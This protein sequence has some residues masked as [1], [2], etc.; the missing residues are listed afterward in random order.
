MGVGGCGFAVEGL[1]YWVA[2]PGIAGPF[3]DGRRRGGVF[4]LFGGLGGWWWCGGGGAGL[5]F[6]LYSLYGGLV[7]GDFVGGDA[8]AVDCVGELGDLRLHLRDGVFIR[9]LLHIRGLLLVPGCVFGW[10]FFGWRWR[11]GGR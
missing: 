3:N 11:I 9:L 8:G 10:V 6:G 7:D 2:F 5:Y 1:F 4:D